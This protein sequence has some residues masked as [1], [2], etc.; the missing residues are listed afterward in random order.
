MSSWGHPFKPGDRV[1]F[2]SP[3]RYPG[4]QLPDTERVGEVVGLKVWQPRGWNTEPAVRWALVVWDD[5]AE[6]GHYAAFENLE[7]V[8]AVRHG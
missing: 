1:R 6:P 2:C 7:L 3:L 5:E 4:P 8:E